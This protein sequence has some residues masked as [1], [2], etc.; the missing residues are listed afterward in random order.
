MI[1]LDSSLPIVLALAREAG[2]AISVI[3][4]QPIDQQGIQYKSDNSP[5]S[6]ADQRAHT[7]IAEGLISHFPTIPILSEE[8]ALPGYDIRKNWPA[9]WLVDPLD[10]TKEFVERTSEFTV[11]IALVVDGFPVLGVIYAPEQDSLYWGSASGAFRQVEGQRPEPIQVER[12][13]AAETLRI[14]SSRRHGLE[15]LKQHL[16]KLQQ[17]T[18]CSVGSSLKFCW[19][20]E[21]RADVY[22]RFGPTSEW[23]TAAGHCILE[24]AGGAVVCLDGALLRYNQQANI[25]QGSFLACANPDLVKYLLSLCA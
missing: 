6:L 23:D 22:P 19:L 24:A 10:G 7:I 12:R 4:R 25:V 20:A 14:L 1:D 15:G 13:A 5:L 21:G 16:P 18:L 3:Y 17:A 11:N 8:S 9:Y 2:R